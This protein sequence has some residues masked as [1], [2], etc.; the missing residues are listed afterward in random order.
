MREPPKYSFTPQAL[1]RELAQAKL[2][3][4][5][6]FKGFESRD[7]AHDRNMSMRRRFRRL[8]GIGRA[9]KLKRLQDCGPNTLCEEV[10][11]CPAACHHASRTERARLVVRLWQRLRDAPANCWLITIVNDGWCQEE[12]ELHAC[13]P[14]TLLKW[15]DR[16]L[17]RLQHVKSSLQGIVGV[18]V[19]VNEVDGEVYWQ[20]H[21]HAVLTGVDKPT[22][23][24]VFKIEPTE[25]TAKPVMVKQIKRGELANAIGYV[26]KRTIERRVGYRDKNG[27][28]DQRTV[29]VPPDWFAEHDLWLVD[30]RVTERFRVI[31]VRLSREPLVDPVSFRPQL[32]MPRHPVRRTS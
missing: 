14:A 16:R 29:K 31:G 17:N 30:Q 21:L 26:V 8:S 9:A 3:E 6:S 2:I 12:G 27:R 7:E 24:K 1:R 4:A 28:R 5:A 25:A 13:R 15:F 20:P 18:D 10:S 22:L 32:K 11:C 23:C 19:S